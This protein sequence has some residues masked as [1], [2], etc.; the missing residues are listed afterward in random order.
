MLCSDGSVAF[1][2][3]ADLCQTQDLVNSEIILIRVLRWRKQ[4]WSTGFVPFRLCPVEFFHNSRLIRRIQQ[5]EIFKKFGD[6]S[7][8]W[9]QIACLAVKCLNHYTKP[10]SVLVWDY[11][12]IIF[13]HG[14]FCPIRLI[15]LIGRKSLHFEKTGLTFLCCQR[16]EISQ[17]YAGFPPCILLLISLPTIYCFVNVNVNLNFIFQYYSVSCCYWW[18]PEGFKL[19]PKWF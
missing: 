4:F 10:F 8:I 5:K 19:V 3:S 16:H 14:R 9:T 1:L 12:S 15:H 13:M 6:F 7:R 2:N 11:N 18:Y 17:F